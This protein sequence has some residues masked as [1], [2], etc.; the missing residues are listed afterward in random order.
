ME[1][2]TEGKWL[3]IG[4][5]VLDIRNGYSR[6]LTSMLTNEPWNTARPSH[7]NYNMVSNPR[8]ELGVIVLLHVTIIY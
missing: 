1:K 3:V 5:V 7:S 6:E 2:H 4:Y 8:L